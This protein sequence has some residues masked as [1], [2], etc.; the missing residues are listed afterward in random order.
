MDCTN[1]RQVA[2]SEASLAPVVERLRAAGCVFAED[3]ARI[4]VDV[5]SDAATLEQLVLRRIAGEPLEYIVG[6]TEFGGLMV[7][8]LPGVFVPRQRSL[9]LVEVAVDGAPPSGVVVD[10]CCGSGALGALFATRLPDADLY[11]AD[12]DPVAVDCTRLNLGHRGQVVCGDL[13]DPLPAAL[14]RRVNVLMCNAPYVP[15]AAMATMPPEAR[16]FEPAGTLDGGPDGLDLL[17]RVA[18]QAPAWLAS[19]GR[20][21]MEVGDSQSDSAARVFD[22]AGLAPSV[23]ADPERGATVIVGVNGEAVRTV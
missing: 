18:V 16:D 20:L 11:A 22:D 12:I 4:L 1:V 15:T 10:L 17:R 3:E 13:F 5:A 6:A 14:R 21:I 9:L 2:E 8:V 7:T 23:H 19:D